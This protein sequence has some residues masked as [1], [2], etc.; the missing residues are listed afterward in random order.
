MCRGRGNLCEPCWFR[1]PE[2]VSCEAESASASCLST[3]LPTKSPDSVNIH[4]R[5]SSQP[6]PTIFPWASNCKVC[7]S[8]PFL[9]L[10]TFASQCVQINL[11]DTSSPFS[12]HFSLTFLLRGF[13]GLGQHYTISTLATFCFLD[14]PSTLKEQSQRRII[15]RWYRKPS[16]VVPSPTDFSHVL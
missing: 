12:C 9:S 6:L 16:P 4:P 14:Y 7:E 2:L 10:P 8:S 11:A 5:R 15:F 1:D 3:Y 13:P